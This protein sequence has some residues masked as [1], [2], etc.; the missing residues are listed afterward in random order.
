MEAT[1]GLHSLPSHQ[2][3]SRRRFQT[4]AS[5]ASSMNRRHHPTYHQTTTLPPLP[6]QPPASAPPSIRPQ[7][8]EDA[9][10]AGMNCRPAGIGD[11][12]RLRKMTRRHCQAAERTEESKQGQP[13]W[14]AR[15]R[16]PWRTQVWEPRRRASGDIGEERG[17]RSSA[18]VRRR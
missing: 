1:Q 8:K 13:R 5:E 7:P 14:R 2:R 9:G 4:A 11:K 15:V 12:T 17:R 16:V 10:V 18:G 3:H 6:W